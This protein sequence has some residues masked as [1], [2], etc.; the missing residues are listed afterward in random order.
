MNVDFYQFDP[1]QPA[2]DVPPLDPAMKMRSWQP[3]RDGLP[4]GG[5][6]RSANYAWWA[7]AKSGGF[8]NPGFTE[9]R[10]EYCNRVLQRLVVT[11]RWYR[12][13]FMGP[14]DLQI[15]D[16]WTSPA[17][18]R[19]QLARIAIAEAHR[20][21]A[22]PGATIWYVTDAGNIASAGLA[23]SCGYRHVATGRRAPRFGV[24]LLAQYVIDR[25]D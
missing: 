9:L 2:Q 11:P 18:R 6:R 7:L 22:G 8:S 15:G 25:F 10:I 1:A 21:F 5:S 13:P 19:Q 3:D 12:F 20:R 17:V 16:V 14:D 24:P 23:R 4:R